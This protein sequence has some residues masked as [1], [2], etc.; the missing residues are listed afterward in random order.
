MTTASIAKGK[1]YSKHN[2]RTLKVKDKQKQ[3]WNERLSHLNIIYKNQP[4][5]EAYEEK[6]ADSVSRYNAKQSRTDRQIKN[7]LEKI[8]RSKQEKP[9]YEVIIQIGSIND[10]STDKYESIQKALDEYN[11]GFQQRNPNFHVFQQITHRDEKGMDH[12]HIQFIPFSTGNKRGLE[13][14]NSLSGALFEM[15]YGRQGFDKWRE[16]EEKTLVQIMAEHNLTFERGNGRSEHYN[17]AEYQMKQQEIVRQTEIELKNMQLPAI[18]EP[19]I[20]VNPLTKNEYIKFSKN[21][22][23]K[24][25]SAIKTQQLQ[26]TSLEAHKKVLE[27]KVDV[28]DKKHQEMRNKPHIALFERLEHENEQLKEQNSKN[29]WL[30]DS[31]NHQIHDL[32]I[33]NK[34]LEKENN[35]LKNINNRYSKEYDTELNNNLHL[36]NILQ[37]I[38]S[39]M[40][41]L[42]EKF[43]FI[44]KM[45]TDLIFKLDDEDYKY[46]QEVVINNYQTDLENGFI[47]INYENELIS[48]MNEQLTENEEKEIDD[49]EIER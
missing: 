45:V 12:T 37:T 43:E 5:V 11:R 27:A 32:K 7:Y 22:F 15:G 30:L 19:E 34:T 16:A 3:S 42:T 20:K 17:V 39:F 35:Y 9:F 36:S 47:Q 44:D 38:L 28:M 18:P 41:F 1:G 25:Q 26:I 24:I 23:E 33:K 8:S 10:K 21:D 13:T 31:K 4:I 48:A 6:F 2:D 14:K 40:F 29:E 49:W 46:Y